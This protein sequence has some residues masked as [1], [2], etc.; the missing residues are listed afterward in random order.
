M[1]ESLGLEVA[2]NKTR[3]VDFNK[4]DFKFVG[5]NFKYWRNKKNSDYKYFMIEPTVE[6][7]KDYKKKIKN[8]IRKTLT[9]S[10]EKWIKRVN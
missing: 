5:F 2:I 4:D 7:F 6:S 9:L 10:E 8:A 1:I 3:F